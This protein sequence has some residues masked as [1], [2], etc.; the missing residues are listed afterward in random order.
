MVNPRVFFVVSA[1]GQK[2]GKMVLE[3]RKDVVPKT[4]ETFRALCTDCSLLSISSVAKK[5]RRAKF[6]NIFLP[7]TVFVD[8]PSSPSEQCLGR[9]FGRY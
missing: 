3:L 9:A 7:A 2:L 6:I 8:H 4:A 1:G 5:P